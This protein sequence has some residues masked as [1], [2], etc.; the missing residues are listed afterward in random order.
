MRSDG[1]VPAIRARL[2]A[3]LAPPQGDYVPFRVDG[4]TVGW[5]DA[6]RA[7]RLRA[8]PGI[9]DDAGPAVSLVA[10][11]ADCRAR[12]AALERVTRAL[13]AAGLLSA[14]RDERYA[15]APQ[16]GTAPLVDIERA[17]AR[18]FGIRTFAV[19]VN[20]LVHGNDGVAMWLARRSPVK[21]IDPGLLDNLVGGGIATG[22]GVVDTLCKEAWEEAGI[23]GSVAASARAEGSLDVCRP[24]RQGLQRETIF[25]YELVLD[26]DFVPANQDGEAVEHRLVSLP[27]AARLIAAEAGPDA[28]TADASLV[29]VDCLLRHEMIAPGSPDYRALSELRRAPLEPTVR[30]DGLGAW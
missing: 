26:A 20:G 1:I 7:A 30:S 9:F 23:P 5:L 3:E 29:I 22:F 14:W 13:A 12:T 4:R 2:A 16:F 6:G 11:L 18:Y 19:H 15:V 10:S 8:F 21:A 25:V 17:A 28:V 24:Q 27:A